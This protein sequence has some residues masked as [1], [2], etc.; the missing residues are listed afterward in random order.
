MLRK[1]Y[2]KVRLWSLYSP[3]ML[4]KPFGLELYS[5]EHHIVKSM[6]THSYYKHSIKTNMYSYSNARRGQHV[7]FIIFYSLYSFENNR[8]I[9]K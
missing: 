1:G 8:I 7:F 3:A 6:I 9:I 2:V 5:F 4:L